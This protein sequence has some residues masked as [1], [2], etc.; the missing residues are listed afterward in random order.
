MPRFKN[1]RSEQEFDET[2][3]AFARIFAPVLIVLVLTTSTY[4]YVNYFLIRNRLFDSEQQLVNSLAAALSAEIDQVRFSLLELARL[5]GADDALNGNDSA[6]TR[7][8]DRML[9]SM[10]DT[11]AFSFLSLLDSTGRELVKVSTLN[12][13]ILRSGL[14]DG[15]DTIPA[16]SLAILRGLP[17]GEVL[18]L[19][20]ESLETEPWL[21]LATSLQSPAGDWRGALVAGYESDFIPQLIS[22]SP[23]FFN[24][25]FW[26]ESA[27]GDVL[28][29]INPEQAG[30][31]GDVEQVTAP[32][33]VASAT[34]QMFHEGVASQPAS[35]GGQ[36]DF[37]R[38]RFTFSQVC[39]L[40][41]CAAAEDVPSP[42]APVFASG[43]WVLVSYL[44]PAQLEIISL[45]R[46]RAS[47]WHPI[48]TLL[49]LFMI[50]AGVV[51]WIF[52]LTLTRLRT[53][54]REV[55]KYFTLHE[56]FFEK[57]PSILFVKDLR[58][59]FYLANE[60]CRRL[61]GNTDV[62]LEGQDR[63][64]V[65][66]QQAAEAMQQQDQQVIARNE[67]ME[68]ATSW[69]RE[70]GVHYYNTLRFPLYDEF[71]E[72]YAVGG[73]ANDIT[74][75]VMSRK[76]LKESEKLLRALLES[77]PEAVIIAEPDGYI[78]LVNREAEI[79]FDAS[80]KKLEGRNL[81]E[82]V[83]AIQIR[84]LEQLFSVASAEG[85]LSRRQV[86][87]FRSADRSF[88]AE[89]SLS[90]VRSSSGNLLICLV[91]DITEQTVMD[92]RLRQSQKLEA[93]GK[94]TGGMAHDFNNLLGIVMGNID[95]AMRKAGGDE[96]LRKRLET[97]KGAAARGAELTKRMLAVARRQ[98]LQP[99]PTSVNQ[100]I[101]EV[102]ALLPRT[103]GPDIEMKIDLK[104]G[105]SPVLVDVSG[106]ENVLINLAI[107]ARDAMPEGGIFS[108][109][110]NQESLDHNHY[111][112][113]QKLLPQGDYIHLIVTDSG[114]GMSK[115]TLSHAFEPFFS[116][117]EKHKGSGLGLSMAY[118]FVKQSGGH[119]HLYS[120]EGRG[121]VVDIYLPAAE[122]SVPTTVIRREDLTDTDTSRFCNK[123][124]LVVDDEP[125]LLDVAVSY[126]E[127]LGFSVLASSRGD[128]ALLRLSEHPEVDLLITDIVMPGQMN[129]VTLVAEVRK[130][131][132]DIKVVYVSGFPSGLIE[133][134][135]GVKMDAPLLNKPYNRDSLA[136]TVA[137]VLN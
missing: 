88:P 106:L 108:I 57:N 96:V 121:T 47:E 58:G 43:N 12:R 122:K 31:E 68:F 69:K 8:E 35:P 44:S 74:D 3:R 103:L 92:A 104:P 118:G 27:G 80:R 9:S 102:A 1:I 2:L 101:E 95:L 125:G 91:R 72:L 23:G 6:L 34:R 120:E 114:L 63:S 52:S 81:C 130:N 90:P 36:F 84:E 37:Q 135:S 77:A 11:P 112:V 124:V 75:Q 98:P 119:I 82:L 13:R 18:E 14:I 86:S 93:V 26:L 87:G 79:V 25:N 109:G 66:P 24:G 39:V 61:A 19:T 99:E 132:P 131:Y 59:K 15:A 105:L 107:N 111:L 78:S 83:P 71:G 49:V 28:V 42:A 129:G 133:D 117:K 89:V 56:A 45:L 48:G 73:I 126:L 100:V 20:G 127:E 55:K 50:T 40:G 21:T 46:S 60:S 29:S 94:L 32:Q 116:T 33:Q 85:Q 38:A 65:F 53:R 62:S 67:P 97:A 137:K 54:E 134:K 113:R 128:E 7:L 123:T 30:T 5:A 17:A 64:A 110:S 22:A 41:P 76:A 16:Q 4:I 136:S 70:D 115:E 10:A 51:T